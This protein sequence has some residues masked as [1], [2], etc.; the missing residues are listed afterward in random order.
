MFYPK[1]DTI[2]PVDKDPLRILSLS[3]KPRGLGGEA[4]DGKKAV[5]PSHQLPWKAN[6]AERSID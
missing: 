1:I 4:T 6:G 3:F 5:S 2:R